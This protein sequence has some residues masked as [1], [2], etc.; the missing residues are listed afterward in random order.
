M[1]RIFA[2]VSAVLI[3]G[4][5]LSCDEDKDNYIDGAV[6]DS[7]NISFKGVRARLFSS[8]LS[9]EYFRNETEVALRITVDVSAGLAAGKTYDLLTE[10]AIT[11]DEVF[12]NLPELKSGTVTL[13][14]FTEKGGS[15]IS[16]SFDAIFVTDKGNE[17]GLFGGFL[18]ELEVVPL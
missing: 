10:G 18:T 14:K 8:E 17:Q 9:I 1:R 12:G 2:L 11:R 4:C 7:F 15:E 16:G 6:K 13:D 3:A 5:L